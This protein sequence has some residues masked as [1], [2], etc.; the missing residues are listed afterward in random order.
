MHTLAMLTHLQN[1]GTLVLPTLDKGQ[2]NTTQNMHT[3]KGE[4]VGLSK[5]YIE[6]IL[7]LVIYYH[8]NETRFV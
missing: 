8:E 4:L 2:S 1:P 7:I 6:T 5:L 3:E